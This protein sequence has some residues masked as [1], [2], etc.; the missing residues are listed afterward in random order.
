MRV[1]CPTHK[2]NYHIGTGMYLLWQFN[3]ICS[4]RAKRGKVIAEKA[5]WFVVSWFHC[6]ERCTTWY[7]MDRSREVVQL[8]NSRAMQIQSV[9]H[10]Q[11]WCKTNRNC[12]VTS[13]NI[14]AK[15]V[16]ST[17]RSS[18]D[19]EIKVACSI[20][21]IDGPPNHRVILMAPPLA[22]RALLTSL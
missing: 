15:P 10:L 4:H 21:G 18:S 20:R 14:L 13:E 19:P 3:R 5:W 6:E 1:L 17:I 8:A 9:L 22:L 16:S 11:K 2:R 7:S 12:S